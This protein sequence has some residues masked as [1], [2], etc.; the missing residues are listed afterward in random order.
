MNN[1]VKKVNFNLWAYI[2]FVIAGL[3]FV[4]FKQDYSIAAMYLGL[5]LVFDPFDVKVAYQLRPMW[6]KTWL[7]AHLAVTFT[8]FML[9]F[10]H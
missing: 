4:L 8:L 9:M 10:L 6:Q 5:A 1:T 3:C 7:V 2:A